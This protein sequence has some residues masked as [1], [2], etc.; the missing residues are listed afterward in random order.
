MGERAL[1]EEERASILEALLEH[2]VA[3]PDVCRESVDA[4]RIVRR[5]PSMREIRGPET[6][7]AHIALRTRARGV[8][9][10]DRVYLRADCLDRRLSAPL[11]LLTHELVH[12]AQYRRDGAA[13]FLSRYLW[14]YARGLARGLG[15]QDAYLDISY[16]REARRVADSV[17]PG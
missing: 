3:P 14:E 10:G 6:A 2:E 15:D 13:R 12:V 16:E 5:I 17:T 4:C 8:T 1:T 11:D 9:L 7:I